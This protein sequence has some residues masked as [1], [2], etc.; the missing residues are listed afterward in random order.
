MC[1]ALGGRDAGSIMRA[2]SSGRAG[3]VSQ[4]LYAQ[5]RE[6]LLERIVAKEWRHGQVLPNEFDLAREFGVSIG[7]IR[8]AVEGLEAAKIVIR[9]QGRG[10]FVSRESAAPQTE[11]VSVFATLIDGGDAAQ[12]VTLTI[13]LRA[14]S[15]EEKSALALKTESGVIEILRCRKFGGGARVL[16]RICLPRH[17]FFDFEPKDPLPSNLYEFYG[18][19]FG[20][21]V[22]KNTEQVTVAVADAEVA[23]ELGIPELS[24]VL[25]ISRSAASAIGQVIEWRVSYCVL[26]NGLNLTGLH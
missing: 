22:V 14:A 7:T 24:A 16:D 11:P 10:T 15:A 2:Q 13:E 25:K 23:Q 1:V 26:P 19:F 20:I 8:K 18:D 5:V 12:I 21:R 17:L 4:P 9:K 3:V 6:R